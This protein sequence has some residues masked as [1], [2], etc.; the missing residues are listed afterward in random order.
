VEG[1]GGSSMFNS[2]QDH[3]S[4]DLKNESKDKNGNDNSDYLTNNNQ[5][6]KTK[7][8][9]RITNFLFGYVQVSYYLNNKFLLFKCR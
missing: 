9:V 6:N 3:K 1:T 2:F 4:K 7:R 8:H 5:S